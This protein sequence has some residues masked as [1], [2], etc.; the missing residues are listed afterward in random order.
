MD[1]IPTQ[2]NWLARSQVRELL[3]LSDAQ[4]R[5]DQAVLLVLD[6]PGFDYQP[7]DEGFSRDS[8]LALWHFR[9]LISTKGRRRAIAEITQ[10]ME[11]YFNE[12]S[13]QESSRAS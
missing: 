13:R 5:R 8:I 1:A 9:Q 3:N 6:V 2:I 12:R 4:L 10:T 11:N 7:Y